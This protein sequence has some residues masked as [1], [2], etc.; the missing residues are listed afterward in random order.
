MRTFLEGLGFT[1]I[2]FTDETPTG[3]APY[4]QPVPKGYESAPVVTAT[5]LP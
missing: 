4:V 1:N 2:T 3:I 5:P